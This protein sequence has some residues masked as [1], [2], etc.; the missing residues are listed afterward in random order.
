VF[1]P[2]DERLDGGVASAQDHRRGEPEG[3]EE[4]AVCLSA[5]GGIAP[6]TLP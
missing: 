2:I 6:P 3:D 4:L 1:E 5:S